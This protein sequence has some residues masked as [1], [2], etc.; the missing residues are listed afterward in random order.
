MSCGKARNRPSS[1]LL[2]S[3]IEAERSAPS[4]GPKMPTGLTTASSMPCPSPSM[5]SQAAFSAKVFDR[6]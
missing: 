3:T 4:T 2:T 5:K 6:G 1:M